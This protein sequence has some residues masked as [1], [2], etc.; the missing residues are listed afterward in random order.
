MNLKLRN[1]PILLLLLTGTCAASD[2]PDQVAV[3]RNVDPLDDTPG[4]EAPLEP[5]VWDIR[6][7]L[8]TAVH[9]DYAGSDDYETSLAPYFRINW[10]D[11]IVLGGRSVRARIYDR[12]GFSVGPLA[13]LRGGRDEDDND[14]LRGL[15][16][17]DRAVEVGG[18]ARYRTG[19]YR[20]RL[21]A[22]HDVGGGHNGAVV[23]MGAGV[24]VPFDRPWFLLMGKATWADQDY[25]SSYFGITDRQAAR[26][27]LRPF[28][29]S[30][31]I[32]DV[33]FSTSSRLTLWRGLSL[34]A[35]LNYERLLG[36]A[37]DSP[38]TARLGDAN[39]LSASTGL[40]YRF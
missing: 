27:G 26:S 12:Q 37:A 35:V 33:G 39:Q 30:A 5:E 17:D 16:D 9:P 6:L 36:D 24:Q 3:L 21:T 34:V 1:T 13:R 4:I 14:D 40:I 22:V 29:A 11:T 25:T 8:L 28:R 38:L 15:G 23:E 10:K 19:P 20:L 32:R 31:G 18:F 7:G 2:D